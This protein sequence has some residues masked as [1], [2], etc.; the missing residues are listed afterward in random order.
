M[1]LE[2]LLPSAV[3]AAPALRLGVCYYPEQWPRER[4]RDDARRMREMGLSVVRIAEFAWALME[5]EP[6]RF[7][8]AWLDEAIAT[9]SAEG[10]QIVLGTPTAA[11]PQWLVQ[12]HPEVLAV[13]A[14]GQTRAAG[15]RRHA[16][17]SSPAY[18]AAS[19]RIVEAMARRYGRHPAVVAWQID[20]EFGCHDTTASY[21]AAA[22]SAFRQWL[23]QR[24]GSIEALNRAWGTVFWSACLSRF[25]EVGAPV[26]QPGGP[27]PAQALD[28]QRFC[29]AQV[30]RFQALQCQLLAEHAPG[31]PVLHN[32]MGLFTELD[33][34]ELGRDLD[35]IAWDSYPLGHTEIA[36]G[37][38]EAQRLRWAC[39]GAPDITAFSHDVYRGVAQAA[40]HGRMWVM[41]QQAG[42]VNWGSWNALPAPGMV[43]AWTWE[44]FAHGAELV[45]YFRWRQLPY[46]QEQMHSGLHTS[47]GQRDH[48]GD[49]AAQV[50][51]ELAALSERL[52]AR[53]LDAQA[54]QPRPAAVALVL[55]HASLWMAQIQPQGADM[56]GLGLAMR[57]HAALRS[58]GLDVDILPPEAP[59]QA[60]ALVVVPMLLHAPPAFVAQAASLP[61]QVVLG[62]RAA[63]KTADF[64]LPVP[65]QP[66]ELAAQLPMRVR[67]VES[68]RPGRQL[69]LR[70]DGNGHGHGHGRQWR[71]LIDA[72]PGLQVLDAYA[73]GWPARVAHGRWQAHA[74][75]VDEATLRRWLAE[76]AAA[77]GLAPMDL[78]GGPRDGLR[79][80]RRGALRFAIHRGEQA[81]PTPAPAGAE[82]LV[83]GPM[84][85]PADVAVWIDAETR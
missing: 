84:L 39:T 76:A 20:N 6:Q 18:V 32:F 43:R 31:R 58:L 21:S 82:F 3:P 74:G 78:Q 23:A 37:L 7:D 12:A 79:I 11:P 14:R 17:L 38:D 1:S 70:G 50:A 9:L 33:A 5:P 36:P 72:L 29:Q 75:V 54:L 24:Y 34:F 73:D 60:Y 64:A 2:S 10:L 45:S 71:D 77:A 46:G 80:S 8:W 35:V 49:E 65:L 67:G 59:L 69:P 81:V 40:G 26:G 83:G 57:Y 51:A 62:P 68:L 44:A 16:D 63:S 47:D 66:A 30:R 61:G 25:D 15:G 53:G 48:G 13:D 22:L 85:Q 28:W 56:P 4:W 55:D 19:Q 52:A 27:L 42:P 41:E